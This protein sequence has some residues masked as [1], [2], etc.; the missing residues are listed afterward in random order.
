VEVD[1]HIYGSDADRLLE[2]L[3]QRKGAPQSILVTGHEPTCSDMAAR[4]IGDNAHIRF[5][6]ATM[7]RIDIPA[8]DWPLIDFGTGELR[9]LMPPKLLGNRDVRFAW[10]HG[11]PAATGTPYSRLE[12]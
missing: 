11:E 9:W 12:K 2:I 4:L 6:T 1:E 10:P 5:P 8:D 3:R 7:A